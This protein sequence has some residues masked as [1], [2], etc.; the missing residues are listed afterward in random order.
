MD[1]IHVHRRLP[2]DRHCRPIPDEERWPSSAGGKG[3]RPVADKVHAMGLKFGIHIM[4]GTRYEREGEGEGEG[5]RDL[6]HAECVC[7]GE[8]C[9]HCVYRQHP[10]LNIYMRP[11][12]HHR[13]PH[14]IIIIIIIIIII[15]QVHTHRKRTASSR[16][17][18]I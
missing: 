13:A 7:V 2:M 3:F 11:L 4:R 16:G 5:E 15:R 1:M 14:H 12:C 10:D 8:L 6:S 18:R 17:V 9:V